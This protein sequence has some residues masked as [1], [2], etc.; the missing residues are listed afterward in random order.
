MELDGVN[1]LRTFLVWSW[2][3]HV[4]SWFGVDVTA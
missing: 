1:K 3:D 4:H 2:C